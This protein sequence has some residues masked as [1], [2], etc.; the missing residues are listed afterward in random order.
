[1]KEIR[2]YFVD[3]ERDKDMR[4]LIQ[5]TITDSKDKTILSFMPNIPPSA[6]E[7]SE[8]E[9]NK[10]PYK[11]TPGGEIIINSPIKDLRERVAKLEGNALDEVTE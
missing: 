4:K 7:I 9:F 10:L 8:S 2:K 3:G 1:M 6:K 5:I 11:L